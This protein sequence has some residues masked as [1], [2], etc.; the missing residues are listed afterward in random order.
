MI[1]HASEVEKRKPD[2]EGMKLD[3]RWKGVHGWKGN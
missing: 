2:D 1:D 3:D